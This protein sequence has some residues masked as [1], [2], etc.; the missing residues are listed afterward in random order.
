MN[1]KNKYQKLAL[2]LLFDA[3]GYV[4]YIIPG[5]AE[6]IDI[7]WAPLSAYLMTKMYKGDK[8]KIAA[9][10]VFIEEAMP[11][12][13]AVPTFT[14]MWFYTYITNKENIDENSKKKIDV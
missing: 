11:W 14:L 9:V 8:G 6:A 13:D 5:I 7:V 10:V 1:R 12:I 3:I 2:S 4:S